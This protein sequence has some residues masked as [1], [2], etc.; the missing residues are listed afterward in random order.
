MGYITGEFEHPT[1]HDVFLT[2]DEK[3]KDEEREDWNI[4]TLD[5]SFS[6]IRT[7]DD[8]IELGKWLVEKG[9]R[10]KKDFTQTGK[11]KRNEK[12]NN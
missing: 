11:K 6:E 4:V 2:V 8:L 7:P 12:A 9:E 1:L 5:T 10:I 3:G